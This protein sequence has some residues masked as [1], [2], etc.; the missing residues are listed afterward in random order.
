MKIDLC[1]VLSIDFREGAK[2]IVRRT[3]RIFPETERVPS[4][5]ISR[6]KEHLFLCDLCVSVVNNKHVEVEG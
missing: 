4:I 6:S 5:G 1:T 2:L 3:T